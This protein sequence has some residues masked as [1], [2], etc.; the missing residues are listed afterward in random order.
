MPPAPPKKVTQ[1]QQLR[2]FIVPSER[3]GAK[4]GVAKRGVAGG[5]WP[6][7]GAGLTQSRAH[8]E[9]PPP[10][11]M[12]GG[13]GE[14]RAQSR[15][16]R[17][18]LNP[19]R[20]DLGGSGWIW[21]VPWVPEPPQVEWG[22]DWE[23]FGVQHPPDGPGGV[24]GDVLGFL[25]CPRGVSGVSPGCFWGADAPDGSG[26]VPGVFLECPRGV[27]GVQPPQSVKRLAKLCRSARRLSGGPCSGAGLR[28]LGVQRGA[29]GGQATPPPPLSPPRLTWGEGL[30]V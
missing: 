22:I 17:G 18:F 3:G 8:T 29:W 25:G 27:F 7:E 30:Q 26:G 1:P 16:G 21:G 10:T 14:H 12:G 23:S 2:G 20:L 11:T 4:Q 9:R 19:P 28:N 13:R 24:P 15:G 5:A 6:S